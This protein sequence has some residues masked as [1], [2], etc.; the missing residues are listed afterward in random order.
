MDRRNFPKLGAAV[1]ALAEAV[2]CLTYCGAYTQFAEG[3]HGRLLPGML[4]DLTV[5]SQDIFAL[6]PDALPGTRADIVLR[7]GVPVL[8][9]NGELA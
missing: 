9:R 7:G 2:H 4:G 6:D 1:L 3:S 5:L 8:D